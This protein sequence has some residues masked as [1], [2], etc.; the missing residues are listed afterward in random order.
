MQELKS[1]LL[2]TSELL[3][4]VGIAVILIKWL[5]VDSGVYQTLILLVLSAL[6]K[7]ARVSKFPVPDYVNGNL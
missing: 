1:T 5:N 4:I 2:H 6:T 7:Y 3:V